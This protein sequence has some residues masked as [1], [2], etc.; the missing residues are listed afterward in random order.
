MALTLAD[1]ARRVANRITDVIQGTASA[2]SATTLTDTSL[3]YSDG[4]FTGGTVFFL[5]G[6]HAGKYAVVTNFSAGVVTFATLTT[7]VGACRYAIIDKTF[8]LNDLIRACNNA[9]QDDVVKITGTD[10]TLTGD[11]STLKFTIPSGVSDIKG[12]E[13]VNTLTTPYLVTPSHHWKERNGEL[14]FEPG[15]GWINYNAAPNSIF[16]PPDDH[17]IRLLYRKEHTELTTYSDAIDTEINEN[18][19]VLRAAEEALLWVIRTR[20]E[21]PAQRFAEF[22]QDVREKMQK[23]RPMRRID[24]IVRT[25]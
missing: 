10:E 20:G 14:I 3:K 5:S 6:T 21:N 15:P 25:A 17:N 16:A 2:G 22:L 18:W 23:V 4:Y 8:P 9:I 11:G 19:L 1:L 13:F 12:V 7:S 24:V